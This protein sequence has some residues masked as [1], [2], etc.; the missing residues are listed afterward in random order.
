MKTSEL[1]NSLINKRTPDS[2]KNQFAIHINSKVVDS[3]YYDEKGNKKKSHQYG[4]ENLTFRHNV[5]DLEK[6][7][8]DTINPFF[9][10]EH[11]SASDIM[12]SINIPTEA[13]KK[14]A[15]TSMYRAI[16]KKLDVVVD[17]E[18]YYAIEQDVRITTIYIASAHISKTKSSTFELLADVTIL[19]HDNKLNTITH[20]KTTEIIEKTEK[21]TGKN[22]N[23]TIILDMHKVENRGGARKVSSKV[24]IESTLVENNI[25]TAE[26]IEVVNQ[27]ADELNSHSQKMEKVTEM[28]AF[29][30]FMK[31]NNVDVAASFDAF[32][33]EKKQPIKPTL[34]ALSNCSPWG[35]TM[36]PFKWTTTKC[37][38]FLVLFVFTAPLF[39]LLIA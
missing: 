19:F 31:K 29:I 27:H 21:F 33:Q 14:R 3:F 39:L 18:V 13:G 4:I 15:H 8:R 5:H 9:D 26:I 23:M 30:E 11:G 36:N 17:H 1:R 25:A 37:V 16:K 12:G 10:A 38:T 2:L 35:S 6:K 22:R 32:T 24:T 20:Y 7:H 28:M 34:K